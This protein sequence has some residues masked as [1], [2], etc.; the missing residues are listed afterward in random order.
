MDMNDDSENEKTLY[1]SKLHVF[2]MAIITDTDT[3]I[4]LHRIFSVLF[5]EKK[6]VFFSFV[7]HSVIK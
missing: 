5:F 2:F 1:S 7:Y 3:D 4:D 6:S